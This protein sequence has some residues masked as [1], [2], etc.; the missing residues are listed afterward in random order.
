MIIVGPNLEDDLNYLANGRRPQ[1]FGKWKTT[2][3]QKKFGD[4]LNFIV[5][6]RQPH[7]KKKWKTTL[8][9][10]VNGRRPQVNLS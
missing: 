10:K 6:G 3:I 8:I 5:N 4:N 2:S 9:S 7:F 1:F